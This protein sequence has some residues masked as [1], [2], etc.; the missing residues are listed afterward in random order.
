MCFRVRVRIRFHA[1]RLLM[2]LPH[3]ATYFVYR[4]ESL[5]ANVQIASGAGVSAQRLQ[6]V[7]WRPSQSCGGADQRHRELLVLYRDQPI[8][9]R[10]ERVSITDIQIL[11]MYW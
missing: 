3:V 1:K 4:E 5:H 9:V 10:P 8:G 6:A 11:V 7:Y 2:L